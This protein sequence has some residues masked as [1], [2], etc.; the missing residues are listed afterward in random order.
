MDRLKTDFIASLSLCSQRGCDLVFSETS[1]AEIRSVREAAKIL[2]H[3]LR[4]RSAQSLI[5]S[6]DV[7]MR[8]A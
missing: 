4:E 8:L 3:P 2:A 7:E 1:T 5:S 6:K